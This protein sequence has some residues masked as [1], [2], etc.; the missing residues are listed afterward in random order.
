MHFWW[1]ALG[2]MTFAMGM[3]IWNWQFVRMEMQIVMGV[4]FF[5]CL[6]RVIYLHVKRDQLREE[7]SKKPRR[8]DEYFWPS[9]IFRDAIACAAVMGAVLFFVWQFGTGL[10]APADPSENFSAARPDWY[11]MSL[12]YL[13]K[14]VDIFTGAFV[15]PGIVAGFVFLMPFIGRWRIGHW[16]NILVSRPS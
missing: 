10:S 8:G 1:V 2:I 15:I 13:L 12:F 5:L 6:A 14:K 7:D 4:L 16:I 3:L 9:Q 11:F